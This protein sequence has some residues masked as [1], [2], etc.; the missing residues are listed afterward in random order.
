M[1][2]S[3]FNRLLLFVFVAI[4]GFSC[5][6][7]DD[8]KVQPDLR[9]QVV[10]NYDVDVKFIA[11]E[12]TVTLEGTMTVSKHGS[13]KNML[14]ATIDLGSWGDETIYL[15]KIVEASNGL[16]FDV[17]SR[18]DTD[19]DGDEF[20][21]LGYDKSVELGSSYYHGMYDKNDKEIFVGFSIVYTE[22]IYS[23]FN[24]NMTVEGK[25]K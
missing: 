3:Y 5:S 19:D 1:K 10:G 18:K 13:D 23:E 8:D 12:G 14:I 4:V 15:N 2:S 21:L 6:K 20:T 11:T 7:D 16:G 22:T 9:E 25:K 24:Y 17:V